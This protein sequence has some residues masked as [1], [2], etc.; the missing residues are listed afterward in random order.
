MEFTTCSSLTLT[1]WLVFARVPSRVYLVHLNCLLCS[2]W[3]MSCICVFCRNRTFC[4]VL[5][6]LKM[7]PNCY[8]VVIISNC[9]DAMVV[10]DKPHFRSA[11]SVSFLPSHTG[12]SG[13]TYYLGRENHNVIT[14]TVWPDWRNYNYHGCELIGIFICNHYFITK[15]F[16]FDAIYQVQCGRSWSK[17]TLID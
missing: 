1:S 12:Y 16:S 7:S 6:L 14:E 17:W 3:K 15:T 4:L 8:Q 5:N 9:W 11:E 13:P 10:R 2:Q